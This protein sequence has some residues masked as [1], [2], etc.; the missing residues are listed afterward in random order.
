MCLI[1]LA[2]RVREDYPLILAANR[3]EFYSR[4]SAPAQFWDDV[5][6]IL[7][8]RDLEKGGTWLGITRTGRLAAVTNYRDG[9]A[10]RAATRSR[11]ALVSGFLASTQG[12]EDYLASMERTASGYDGFNLLVGS[13]RDGL[14]YYSNRAGPPHALAPG[15]H[16]LSNH[17]LNS[18]WPKVARGKSGLLGLLAAPRAELVP[19]LFALLE[20]Q[21]RPGDHELP[22]TGVGTEW[23]RVLSTAFIRTADYGTRCTTVL[24][25]DAAGGVEFIEHTHAV[26]NIESQR[27]EYAF[28]IATGVSSAAAT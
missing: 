2:W 8:G 6:D 22:D 15:V 27:R 13:V 12:A 14:H 16:G 20:D 11:G 24:L 26:P 3:D 10:R 9:R 23:E 21:T 7:A 5:P 28:R 25:A 1:L 4:P 18:P 17:R 19:A